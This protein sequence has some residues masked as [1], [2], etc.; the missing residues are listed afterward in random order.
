MHLMLPCNGNHPLIT[1]NSLDARGMVHTRK[2]TGH[3]VLNIPHPHWTAYR[4]NLLRRWC[5]HFVHSARS[6]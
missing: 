3:A 2:W 1:R 5:R 6:A 4:E